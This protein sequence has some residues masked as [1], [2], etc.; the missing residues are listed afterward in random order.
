MKIIQKGDHGPIF[1]IGSHEIIDDYINYIQGDHYL[2][3]IFEVEDWNRDFS[4]WYAL[5]PVGEPFLGGGKQTLAYLVDHIIQEVH[6]KYPA[7][8]HDYICG[9]SLAGLF[10]LWAYLDTDRFKG[11]VVSSASLWFEGFMD[12]I[13]VHLPKKDTC[14]YLS[15]GGK[16][17][18]SKNQVMAQIGNLYRELYQKYKED[19]DIR[20]TLKM[21]PG[22]HFTKTIER[23]CEGISWILLQE[24]ENGN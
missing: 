5:S 16:E 6:Q 17:E 12:Y 7:Y 20:V 21:N 14:I 8:H 2:L 13:Q 19:P 1:Y 9:Y 4:P 3:V 23:V 10:A 24:K 18:K 22:G 11:C 15:L